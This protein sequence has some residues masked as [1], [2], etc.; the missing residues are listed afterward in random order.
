MV[1]ALNS[2]L[3]SSPGRSSA[4]CSWA[5][6]FTLIVPPS[7]QVYTASS[8]LS[9]TDKFIILLFLDVLAQRNI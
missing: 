6:Q 7:T 8:Y 2:G 3:G 1:S 4:L 9:H 5:K